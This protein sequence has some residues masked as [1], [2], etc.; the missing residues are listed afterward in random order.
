MRQILPSFFVAGFPAIF[1]CKNRLLIKMSVFLSSES[2]IFTTSIGADI[3]GLNSKA[4][5]YK[6]LN[7]VF[8]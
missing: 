2:C 7:S 8:E 3:F 5:Y 1:L 6:M 4:E